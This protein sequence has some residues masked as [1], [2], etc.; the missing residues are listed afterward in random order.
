MCHKT[1]ILGSTEILS[2]RLKTPKNR[3][4]LDD[5]QE[6]ARL[7]LKAGLFPPPFMK[8]ELTED[9]KSEFPRW[10]L[11]A[12]MTKMPTSLLDLF[13]STIQ[14]IAM[15]IDRAHITIRT[16]KNINKF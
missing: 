15:L 8:P 4:P 11:W 3:T 2:D 7:E 16:E 12:E 10:E 9:D 6:P 13:D 5:L 1:F 14:T